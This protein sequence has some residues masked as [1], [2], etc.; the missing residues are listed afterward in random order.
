MSFES[1][2]VSGIR[3]Q[4]LKSTGMGTKIKGCNNAVK[5]MRKLD[6]EY[7]TCTHTHTKKNNATH[8]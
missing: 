4:S 8:V 3:A 1:W 6:S 7:Y 5:M 2:I